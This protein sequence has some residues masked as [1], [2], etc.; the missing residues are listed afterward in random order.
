MQWDKIACM[1]SYLMRKGGGRGD[2]K[3]AF[4]DHL[5][6]WIYCSNIWAAH[7]QQYIANIWAVSNQYID[8]LWAILDQDSINWN[9]SRFCLFLRRDLRSFSW[10]NWSL[11]E[12]VLLFTSILREN[13]I[14]T[15]TPI[16]GRGHLPFSV[17]SV[18]F[19]WILDII[20]RYL[21]F[22]LEQ[23]INILPIFG[24]F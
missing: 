19:Y 22:V 24:R 9:M 5:G 12:I 20:N 21:D 7:R 13:L 3:H 18:K 15:L 16:F 14:C 23:Y 8:N 17:L 1:R 2:A 10:F 4:K 6:Y 11:L